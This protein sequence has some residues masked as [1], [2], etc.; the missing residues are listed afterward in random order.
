MYGISELKLRVKYIFNE[1]FI[2]EHCQLCDTN[3]K[4]EVFGEGGG[5][6]R[7]IETLTDDGAPNL[8]FASDVAFA[9]RTVLDLEM[10][11]I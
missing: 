10:H 3:N 4:K 6:E 8:N 1:I 11:N 9:R 2:S 5:R 7:E